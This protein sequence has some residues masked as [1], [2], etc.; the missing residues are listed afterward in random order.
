[1]AKHLGD[2]GGVLMQPVRPMKFVFSFYLFLI[3]F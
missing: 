2:R 1:M 3:K